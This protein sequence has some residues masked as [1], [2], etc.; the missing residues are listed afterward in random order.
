MKIVVAF[1]LVC[2]FAAAHGT[3]IWAS[4]PFNVNYVSG[5]YKVYGLTVS[6]ICPIGEYTFVALPGGNQANM[7][8]EGSYYVV[9]GTN[10]NPNDAVTTVIHHTFTF[11]VLVNPSSTCTV[12]VTIGKQ[13]AG[14]TTLINLDNIFDD[15]TQL[16]I[17]GGSVLSAT[18]TYKSGYAVGSFEV[19]SVFISNNCPPG[20]YTLQ[21]TQQGSHVSLRHNGQQMGFYAF[22]MYNWQTRVGMQGRYFNNFVFSM[23]PL[24]HDMSSYTCYLTVPVQMVGNGIGSMSLANVHT[25]FDDTAILRIATS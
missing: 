12:T 8:Y 18:S 4:S 9:A 1:L 16:V 17:V 3:S 22:N 13:T 23:R 21:T 11:S 10:Y 25:L 20:D 6:S 14:S 15:T 5:G 19:G 24:W 2:C 7:S